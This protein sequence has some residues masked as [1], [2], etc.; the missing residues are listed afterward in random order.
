[1]NAVKF[2]QTVQ[3]VES[4][5]A[6]HPL[7]PMDRVKPYAAGLTIEPGTLLK[8]DA[9]SYTPWIQGTDAAGLIAGVCA[10]YAALDTDALSHAKV[11]LF[12][13]VRKAKLIAWTNAGGTTTAG[14]SAA[15]LAQLESLHLFPL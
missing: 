13:P 1:M 5:N 7:E 4:I 10:H 11:R 2:T 12:G 3:E 9:G 8:L 14:P 6:A 15:A